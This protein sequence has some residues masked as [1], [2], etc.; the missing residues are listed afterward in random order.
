MAGTNVVP[1]VAK[2]SSGVARTNRYQV[3]VS[4]G[5]TQTLRYDANGNMV[6]RTDGGSSTSYEWDA[7]NRL[8][9]V[10]QGTHRS[11]FAYDGLSRR[12]RIIE[13]E[14]A[15]VSSDKRFVWDSATIAEERGGTGAVVAKRFFQQGVQ[16][17]GIN[18]FYTRD[19]LGSVRE[20]TDGTGSVRARYDY[21][22]YGRKT[23]LSGDLDA[24]FGFTGH[25]YHAASG[26]WLTLYRA[27][28]ADLGRWGSRDPI[29][30][31]GGINLYAYC[32]GEP[33]N[34]F[35]P[36]GLL[37]LP[38]NPSGLPPE[39]RIDPSHQDPNGMRYRAPNGDYI[40]FHE[41]RPGED[42]WRA[43]DHW[44]RNGDGYHY[45]PGDTVPDPC[46]PK[47]S[48]PVPKVPSPIEPP[49]I[50]WWLRIAPK[51]PFMFYFPLPDYRQQTGQD[52]LLH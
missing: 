1:V 16:V 4:G 34:W 29:E 45:K 12:V 51:L 48:S 24:D 23:K 36:D 47:T 22:P 41:G 19:H 46:P 50:P 49:S 31:D 9:A 11:E 5:I 33:V 25:Y 10:N 27:Y 42:G 14:N 28:D 39:W 30:E 43:K 2:S 40:D 13:K 17:S 7:V 15:T 3:V 37:D 52:I 44:H 18:Y 26:L 35:D 20:L 21:D 6:S 38:N 32:N 8:T